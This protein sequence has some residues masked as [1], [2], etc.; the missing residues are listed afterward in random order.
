[1]NTGAYLSIQQTDWLL[2]PVTTP[3]LLALSNKLES[4]LRRICFQ[5]T[6]RWSIAQIL[7]T[8]QVDN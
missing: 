5:T 3:V 8:A 6:I 4:I 7:S 2:H 1:M